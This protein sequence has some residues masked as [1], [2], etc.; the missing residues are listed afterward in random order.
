MQQREFLVRRAKKRSPEEEGNSVL[1]SRSTAAD[2]GIGEK[3]PKKTL[4]SG[5]GGASVLDWVQG[6]RM[7][8][9]VCQ[10]RARSKNGHCRPLLPSIGSLGNL[11]RGEQ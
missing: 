3:V 9:N 6:L 5:E 2:F 1:R 4:R 11:M 10:E 8:F 7:R